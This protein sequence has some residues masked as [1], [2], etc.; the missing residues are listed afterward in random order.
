MNIDKITSKNL[1][2]GCGLC[3]SV[4]PKDAI[5]Y[6]RNSRGEV[7][8]KIDSEKCIDC[9]LCYN[10]C[11]QQNKCPQKHEE[12]I[13]NITEVY[14]GNSSHPEILK[15][16]QSGAGIS[17]FLIYLLENNYIQGAVVSKFDSQSPCLSKTFIAKTKEEILSSQGSLY[18]SVPN[19]TI[20]KELKNFDG[21]VAFVGTGCQI[22]A[23]QNYKLIQDKIFCYLGVICDRAL[24]LNFLDFIKN[25][26]PEIDSIESFEFRSKE[27]NG[28]PGDIKL[29]Q[30]FFNKKYRLKSKGYFSL[31]ACDRCPNKI[32]YSADI[33]FGDAW[34]FPEDKQG[35]SIIY[36][37][38]NQKINNLFKESNFQLKKIDKQEGI[39][40]QTFKPKTKLADSFHKNKL[41]SLVYKILI[42]FNNK[43]LKNKK[44]IFIYSSALEF[45]RRRLSK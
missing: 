16:A 22:K 26:G 11:P 23:C 20:I 45:T 34:N 35:L 27:K 32:N 5:S 24:S 21:Q 30:K 7:V 13:N 19:N 44:I 31:E 29:N 4:C 33:T 1:C 17:D 43:K 36:L 38:D 6:Y 2:S 41:F 28:W 9:G 18:F 10:L 25:Q 42:K 40:S 39:S 15:K 14:T 12:L 3:Q 8:P 37:K